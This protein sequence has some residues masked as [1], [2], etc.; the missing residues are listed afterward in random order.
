[1]KIAKPIMEI[2]ANTRNVTWIDQKWKWV[3]WKHAKKRK[4]YEHARTP[5]V[6]QN[7]CNEFYKGS[8]Y[9]DNKHNYVITTKS[10][11]FS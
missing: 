10:K 7:S 4:F 9:L 8:I 1:M 3:H 6:L 2:L 5:R 11:N